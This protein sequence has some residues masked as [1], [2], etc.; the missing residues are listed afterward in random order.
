MT[1][2]PGTA[3]DNLRL[4]AYLVLPGRGGRAGGVAGQRPRRQAPARAGQE[5]P[6][7][8]RVA[9]Q[10]ERAGHAAPLVRAAGAG[11]GPA[12]GGSLTPSWPGSAA[13]GRWPRWG[14]GG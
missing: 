8:L 1:D 2:G 10:A 13:P 4:L 12:G 11:P 9:L 5:R 6:A 14:I 7:G 3:V